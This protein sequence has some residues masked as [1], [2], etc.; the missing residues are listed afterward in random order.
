MINKK[1]IL[2]CIDW[3]LPAY[4]AGGP[5]QSIN[6]IISHFNNDINFWIYTS[7]KDLNEDL[8]LG[9][10]KLNTWSNKNGYRIMYSDKN[11]P[12]FDLTLES[13]HSGLVG[14][15]FIDPVN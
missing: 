4:K 2:V 11:A 10:I 8:D 9:N 15:K 12:I 7:N 6:N 13:Y 1:N 14:W 3:F 5:I